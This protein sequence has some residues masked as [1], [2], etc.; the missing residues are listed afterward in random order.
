MPKVAPACLARSTVASTS[1]DEMYVDH[2]AGIS[3][4][5]GFGP[6]PATARPPKSAVT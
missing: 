4:P 1:D 5:S 3:T 6:M 2:T